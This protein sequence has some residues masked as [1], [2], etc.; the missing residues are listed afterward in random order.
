MPFKAKVGAKA[1]IKLAPT[2]VKGAQLN[3]NFCAKIILLYGVKCDIGSLPSGLGVVD[4]IRP[5]LKPFLI[6]QHQQKCS[7]QALFKNRWNR[8]S[9]NGVDDTQTRWKGSYIKFQGKKK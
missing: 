5:D 2:V 7:A 9:P 1:Q 3:Q 8:R 6:G 4:I